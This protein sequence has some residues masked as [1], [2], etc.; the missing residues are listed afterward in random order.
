M[1]ITTGSILAKSPDV[2]PKSE[3]RSNAVSLFGYL[4]YRFF[5]NI[6]IYFNN[7]FVL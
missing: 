1:G 6:G 3:L 7:I 2:L 5:R 4:D